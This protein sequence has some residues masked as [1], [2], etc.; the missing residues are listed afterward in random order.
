MAILDHFDSMMSEKFA[1]ASFNPWWNYVLLVFTRV[2]YYPN[3]KF[4]PN[5]LSKKQAITETLIP[6]IQSKYNLQQPPKYAFISSKTPNCSY[7]KKGQCD[8]FAVQKY[9]LDQMRTLKLRVN[10]ILQENGGRWMPL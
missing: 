5:V 7:N 6:D 9:H 2:D 4:P 8:C 1:P 3:L 10:A